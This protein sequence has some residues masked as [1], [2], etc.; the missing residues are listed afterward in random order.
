LGVSP[1]DEY[2]EDERRGPPDVVEERNDRVEDWQLWTSRAKR[3]AS[4]YRQK[5]SG[6]IKSDGRPARI[7]RAT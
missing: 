1:N 2:L 7:S 3:I 4:A 6:S 5:Q